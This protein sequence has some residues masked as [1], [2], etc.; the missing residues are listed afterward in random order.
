MRDQK[1]VV[2]SSHTG[3]TLEY[4][5]FISNYYLFICESPKS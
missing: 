3:L 1:F 4:F 5:L 2:L